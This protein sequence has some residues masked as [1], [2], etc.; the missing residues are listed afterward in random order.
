MDEEEEEDRII[1]S[2]AGQ[3]RCSI[4]ALLSAW[5]LT[6]PDPPE[7]RTR[8]KNQTGPGEHSD[9]NSTSKRE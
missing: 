8:T 9:T 1:Y 4:R 6:E 2:R 5:V 3:K 7:P